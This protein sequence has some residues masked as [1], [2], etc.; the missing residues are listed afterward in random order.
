MS[1]M[2]TSASQ[3]ALNPSQSTD[4]MAVLD[5]GIRL[6]AKG[7]LEWFAGITNVF[8]DIYVVARRPYGLRPGMPRAF[9]AGATIT[10]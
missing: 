3:G 10:F 5:A 9:R 4:A 1:A 8:D 7:H 2:R 6:Q